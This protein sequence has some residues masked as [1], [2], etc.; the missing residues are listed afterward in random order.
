MEKVYNKLVRDKIP[1][2][3][4]SKGEIPITRTLNDTEYR[5]ELYKKLREECEEVTKAEGTIEVLQ[6]LADV[7]EV[8][9][10]ISRLEN[11]NLENVIALANQ[12]NITN[13][14]FENRV[15]LEKKLIK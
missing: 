4:A 11:R 12:K 9:R 3:I 10:A 8:V 13:G 14:G 5:I 2:I 15:F 1:E 7:L 6:E